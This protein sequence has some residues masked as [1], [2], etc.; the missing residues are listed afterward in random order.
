MS[1]R[2]RGEEEK[3]D[4]EGD[5]EVEED[6]KS[7]SSCLL[8]QGEY[9]PKTPGSNPVRELGNSEEGSG[10]KGMFWLEVVKK[11]VTSAISVT[12]VQGSEGAEWTCRYHW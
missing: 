8:L 12:L 4:E 7:G 3:E 5:E 2:W 10:K 6:D 11:R 1:R 9:T